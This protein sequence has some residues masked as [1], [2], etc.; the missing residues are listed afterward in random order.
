MD[1]G[2]VPYYPTAKLG[3]FGVSRECY[4][5][6]PKNPEHLMEAGTR[7]WQAPVSTNRLTL[8]EAAEF[9]PGAATDIL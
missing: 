7:G 9:M 2:G 3:D 1:S 8:L 4:L 5:R 6:D